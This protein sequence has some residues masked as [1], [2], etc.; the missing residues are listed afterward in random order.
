MA[1]VQEKRRSS[2]TNMQMHTAMPPPR[3]LGIFL[4]EQEAFVLFCFVFAVLE[5]FNTV[6]LNHQYFRF[7]LY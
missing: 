2:S 3:G 1:M 7:Q 5:M 4:T 6:G